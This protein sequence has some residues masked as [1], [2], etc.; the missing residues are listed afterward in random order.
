MAGRIPDILDRA[1]IWH[2]LVPFERGARK[3]RRGRVPFALSWL[4]VCEQRCHSQLSAVEQ[5]DGML[6]EV[7]REPAVVLLQQA[8][9]LAPENFTQKHLVLLPTKVTF[10]SHAAHQHIHG[11]LRF[12]HV[13]RKF[14][15]G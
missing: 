1:Y 12:E 2:F 4:R 15:R 13:L 5:G 11:I 14:S 6:R 7:D 10:A 8:Y 9:S 3:G